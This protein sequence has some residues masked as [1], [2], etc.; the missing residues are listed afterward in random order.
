FRPAKPPRGL[1]LSTGEDSPRGQ[2]LRA[3]IYLLE[4]SPGDLGPQQPAPNPKLTA[5]QRDAA[6][7][8]YAQ[9]LAGFLRRL[10]ANYDAVRGRLGNELAELRDQARCDGQHARTPGMVA[11]LAL[12]L[13]YFLEFAL[14]VGAI[15]DTERAELWERGWSAFAETARAQAAHL[16]T[17]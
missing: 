8:K 15:S 1:I 7:G 11:D 12:G 13:R 4:I 6:S 3:R 5:C 16:A 14:S 10:A 17:A 2:S 9:A